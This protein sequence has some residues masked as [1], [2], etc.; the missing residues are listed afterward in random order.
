[1]GGRCVGLGGVGEGRAGTSRKGSEESWSSSLFRHRR[2]SLRIRSQLHLHCHLNKLLLLGS[3]SIR[4]KL[5]KVR[6]CQPNIALK[7]ATNASIIPV[8]REY[9]SFG[10]VQDS[11]FYIVEAILR[12]GNNSLICLVLNFV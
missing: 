11:K 5:T 9:S 3:T 2:G 8:V 1:M 7:H 10:Y 6:F 12:C 4:T